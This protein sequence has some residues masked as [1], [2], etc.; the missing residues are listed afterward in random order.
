MARYTGRDTGS[1]ITTGGTEEMLNRVT[2]I[3]T[4]EDYE[5]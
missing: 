1:I 3:D 2:L 4:S 5:L